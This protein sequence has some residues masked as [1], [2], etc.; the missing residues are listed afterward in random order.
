MVGG[1]AMAIEQTLGN[2][3]RCDVVRADGWILASAGQT[4]TRELLEQIR[5]AGLED[6]LYKAVF[7][8][9]ETDQISTRGRR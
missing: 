5:A 7:E 2:P 8:A 9:K 4:V 3:L 1:M 6:Q